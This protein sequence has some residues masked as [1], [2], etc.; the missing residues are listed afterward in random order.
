MSTNQHFMDNRYSC[1]TSLIHEAGK[2]TNIHVY[3]YKHNIYRPFNNRLKKGK[4]NLVQ[5]WPPHFVLLRQMACLLCLGLLFLF[6][7]SLKTEHLQ[8]AEDNACE[9]WPGKEELSRLGKVNLKW[10]PD[11]HIYYEVLKPIS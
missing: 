2:H 5:V 6:L 7:Q 3:L 4:K 10:S 11:T 8:L 1:T 9:N